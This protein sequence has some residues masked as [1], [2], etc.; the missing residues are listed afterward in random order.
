MGRIQDMLIGIAIG[1]AYGAAYEFYPGGREKIAQDL[2][3]SKY[4]K[5][6]KHKEHFE[7]MYTDDTQMSIA[8]AEL[9]L[10]GKAF[11]QIN[12]ADYFV[13]CFKR[14][15]IKGYAGKFQKFLESISSGTDFL[16]KIIPKSERNGAIMRSVPI[17]LFDDEKIVIEYAIQNAL[18]THNTPGGIASSVGGA[19]LS[20][21][22]YHDLEE[23][24]HQSLYEYILPKIKDLDSA[25]FDYLKIIQSMDTPNYTLFFG[26]GREN[27]GVACD[28]R[29]TLGAVCYLLSQY[30]DNPA[31]LLKQATLLGGDTDS[32]A[33]VA[34]GIS[35]AKFGLDSLPEFLVRDLTNRQYGRD[36][37]LE[38]GKKLEEKYPC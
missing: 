38:L 13:E 8:I 23:K 32:V 12:L 21:F 34:L 11:N 20:Q 37:L 31:D 25:T 6:F 29:M 7:G 27:K 10:S 4:S 28:G 35:A 26:E 1:D 24:N 18:T 9:I 3:F 5:H 30:G 33:A 15:P 19:L 16:E 14:D 17:G 36:Y 22:Y 2:D